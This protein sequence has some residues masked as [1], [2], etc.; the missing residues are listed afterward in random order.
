MKMPKET[1]R[2]RPPKTAGEA[3]RAQFGTRLRPSL[4]AAL[5]AAAGENG[6]SLSEEI[7]ARLEQSF[8]L[9]ELLGSQEALFP[10][11]AFALAGKTAAAV[12]TVAGEPVPNWLNDQHCYEEA[13]LGLVETFWLQHPPPGNMSWPARRY[14]LQRLLGRL[15]KPFRGTLSQDD[16]TIKPSAVDLFAPVEG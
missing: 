5:D 4:K 3:K 12:S 9:E 11:V 16:L 10:A 13:G 1:R 7:E 15:A 8:A 2:G 14:W 6:R